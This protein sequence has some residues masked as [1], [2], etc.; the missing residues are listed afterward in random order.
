M[1]QHQPALRFKM[2]Q[3]MVDDMPDVIQPIFA[4]HQR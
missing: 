1:L 4:S 3:G 2:S